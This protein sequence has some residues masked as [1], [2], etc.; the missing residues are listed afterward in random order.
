MS[1]KAL[2]FLAAFTVQ[3][4]YGVTY[5]FANDV[6]DGGYIA[7]YGFILIRVLGAALM[8]WILHFFVPKEKIAPKDFRLFII[9]SFFGLGLNMLTFFK[10]LSYTTPIHASVIMVVTPIIVLALSALL[11]KEKVTN[12]K[13]LGIFIGLIGAVVLTVYGKATHAKDNILWGNFLIFVNAVSFSIYLIILKKLTQ[14]YHPFTFMKWLTLFGTLFVLPFGFKELQAVE[15][16]TFSPYIYFSVAFSVV[17]TTFVAYLLNPIALRTLKASTVSTFLYVQPV[18]AT[19]FAILMGSDTFNLT[20]LIAAVL[21]FIGVY[22]VS[23]PTK[24]TA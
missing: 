14:K 3:V 16:T 12:L 13:V 19:I 17:I 24:I 21:I 5:T 2:A 22:L 9:A 10:G 1:K 11:L 4:I 6:I 15:W 7:P 20:K 23:K 18:I 8:F